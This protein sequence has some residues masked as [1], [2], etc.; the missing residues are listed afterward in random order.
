MRNHQLRETT[1]DKKSTIRLNNVIGNRLF[2]ETT[3][4]EKQ[5]SDET[6]HEKQVSDET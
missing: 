3:S 6:T 4:R 2:G 1:S 5:L